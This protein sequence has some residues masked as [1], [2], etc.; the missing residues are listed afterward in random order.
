MSKVES[1]VKTT[2]QKGE[3]AK[4]T[5][6]MDIYDGHNT[7]CLIFLIFFALKKLWFFSQAIHHD[8]ARK[9]CSRGKSWKMFHLCKT[10]IPLKWKKF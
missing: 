1:K 5:K 8:F 6:R 3:G 10:M 7:K 2:P 9:F 4:G